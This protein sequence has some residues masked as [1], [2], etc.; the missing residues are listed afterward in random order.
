MN[1]NARVR[2]P[3]GIVALLAIVGTVAWVVAGLPAFDTDDGPVGYVGRPA[4]SSHIVYTGNVDA[5]RTRL[6]AIDYDGVDWAGNLH[7]YPLSAAGAVVKTDDW[8]NGAAASIDVQNHDS[9]RKIVTRNGGANVAFRWAA[10]STTQKTQLG[11]DEKILNYIRGDR[12]N[13]TP[14]G[15]DYRKRTSVL[16]DIIHSTPVYCGAANCGG[17]T[18]FVGA[19]DGMVHAINAADGSERFAFIP[20]VLFPKLASLKTDPYVHKHYV[21]GSMVLARVGGTTIL[22][23]GLGAGG[24][25]LYALNV[26]NAAATSEDDAKSKILW[27]ISNQTTGFGNLGYTYGQPVMATAL[28]VT[29]VG[30]APGVGSPV[31][32]PVLVVSNGYNSD[33]GRAALFLINASNGVLIQEIVTSDAGTSSNRNGLSSPT[34]VDADGDGNAEYA[35][36]GDLDG[37]L[38]K[39]KLTSPYSATKLHTVSPAQSITMAPGLAPHPSGG[40]MVTFVTGRMLVANDAT[41]SATHY[42]YGIWDA[43]PVANTSLFSQTLTETT[44]GSSPGIRVRTAAPTD[45]N[46]NKKEPNWTGGG[47]KGWKTALPV[48]GERVVGDGAYAVG[49]DF[50]FLS[51]NPTVT[52]TPPAPS[53]ANWYMRLNAL[54]GGD[55]GSVRFDLNGDGAYTSADQVTVSGVATSP[56]GKY[57]GGGKRSQFIAVSVGSSQIY[58]ANYDKNTAAARVVDRGVSGG[59]FDYDI[60]YATGL[61]ATATPTGPTSN[62]NSPFCLKTSNVNNELGGV[63][64]TYCNDTNAAKN[65]YPA[66][67]GYMTA[68]STGAACGANKAKTNRQTIT[69]SAYTIASTLDGYGKRKHVHEYDDIYDVTGVNM[70][71][72]SDSSFNLSNVPSTIMSA[73]TP[74]KVLVM[75]QYLNPAVKL[76]IGPN[77]AQFFV[78]TYGNLA[79]ETNATTLLAGLPTYTRSNIGRFIFNLPLDAFASKDWWGDGGAARA[80]LI[81]TQTG[82]VNKPDADGNSNR[83][84]PQTERHN[85]ALTIQLIKAATPDSALEPN[86]V[87]NGVSDVRYGWRVKAAVFK[88]YVLAEYTAFWH[89]PNGKCYGDAGWVINPP[90][91]FTS[92]ANAGTPAAGSSDPRDGVFGGAGDQ[93]PTVVSVVTNPDGSTTTTYSDGTVVIDYPD[94]SQQVTHSDGTVSWNIPGIDTGG[95]VTSEGVVDPGGESGPAFPT[96]R[97]NWRQL[98]R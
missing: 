17:A 81:P 50:N 16:G 59:H 66:N 24:K 15:Q 86:Y 25:G 69:C 77:A 90:Q 39:F 26:T 65:G 13:E 32:T 53:G 54:T 55:N 10:L 89:H 98:G 45:P 37:N 83:P 2:T 12:S 57:E 70:L 58:H 93:A 30:G 41:D 95:E 22:A 51:T 23:G 68:L 71:A 80:G 49:S 8:P 31:P 47:D 38:W 61:Q 44:W 74:F 29:P 43:A 11:N 4:V 67:Y 92:D 1:L 20:S 78:K 3:A 21:D 27:E 14:N 42:A 73:S 87:K 36:A 63:A 34:V 46:P 84:G 94:G 88:Q 91:D 6:Y 97:I 75:N 9:G 72:A 60:Y 40:F 82:C 28:A 85:G 19:N 7:S 56:V 79:S 18:V 96:G 33:G 5:N 52:A 76:A 62:G 35:Y 64:P 48:G